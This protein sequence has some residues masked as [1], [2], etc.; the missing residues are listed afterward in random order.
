VTNAAVEIVDLCMRIVGGD[1]LLRNLPLERCYRD[2]RAGLHNPPMDDMTVQ[3][4]ADAALA[5]E[6][7]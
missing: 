3:Q 1:S 4:L 6:P 2:V 5:E 7:S